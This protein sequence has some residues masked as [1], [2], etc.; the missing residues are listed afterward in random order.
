MSMKRF[1]WMMA[2]ILACG[3]FALSSCVDN[4]D[5]PV[6]EPVE[7]SVEYLVDPSTRWQ[8]REEPTFIAGIG[9]LPM[10]FQQ[11]LAILS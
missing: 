4:D 10:E 1:Y 9:A 2:A 5:N 11:A 7:E 3:S 6:S 8:Q